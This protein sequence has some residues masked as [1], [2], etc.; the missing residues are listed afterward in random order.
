MTVNVK[1]VVAEKNS[2]CLILTGGFFFCSLRIES[3]RF[4]WLPISSLG[5]PSHWVLGASE[6]I[7]TMS[8]CQDFNVASFMPLVRSD[9][10]DSTVPMLRVV[11]VD[12]ERGPD[13]GMLER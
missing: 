3:N 9:E 5:W 6:L 4:Y 1:I 7:H 8:L 11:P 2:C 13:A 10:S 12:E